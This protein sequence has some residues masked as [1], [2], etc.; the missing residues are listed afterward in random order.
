MIG[1]MAT[2]ADPAATARPRSARG[3]G[4]T[5]RDDLLTA[6]A[7]LMAVHGE[8]E[9]VSLR[10]VARRA[11]VSATAVYRHFDDHLELLRA[12]VDHCWTTFYDRLRDAAATT[13]D[14]FDAFRAMG[15]AYVSYALERTGEYRVLFSDKV[16][17][18]DGQSPG[19]LAAFQLLVDAVARILDVLGDPRDPFF[20][21][22]QVHTWVH[23]IV[24]LCGSHPD[25]PW[26][27]PPQLLDGLSEALRLGR[28]H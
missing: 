18:G 24:D 28:P 7:E 2:A 23:G 26:P 4:D 1:P 10:A 16:D 25:M 11:G 14:P 20:V 12:T 3:E 5:L 6:A 17:L 8:M 15:D 19:G 22:V 27:E 21:A 9:A 13:D